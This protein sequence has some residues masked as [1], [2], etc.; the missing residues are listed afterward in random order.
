[1]YRKT[2][3]PYRVAAAALRQVVQHH[4]DLT[5]DTQADVAEIF[6]RIG[7]S[8]LSNILNGAAPTPVDLLVQATREFEDT[9]AIEE[10][11]RLCGGVFTALPAGE[12][13]TASM[14]KVVREFGE[15]LT[16]EAQALE[17]GKITEED[18]ARIRKEGLDVISVIHAAIANAEYQAKAGKHSDG[19]ASSMAEAE[20]TNRTWKR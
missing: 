15:Y 20:K 2:S 17:D 4:C 18:A 12:I 5:G 3:N 8:Y 11:C 14:A 19:R 1:M 13:N 7:S 6:G 9:H 10:V 16:A